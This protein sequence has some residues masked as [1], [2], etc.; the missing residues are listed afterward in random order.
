MDCREVQEKLS[1]YI[2]EEVLP[3]EKQTIEEHLLSCFSCQRE[4]KKLLAIKRLLHTMDRALEKRYPRKI[5]M[6]LQAVSKRERF[7]ELIL[8]FLLS[9]V[10]VVSLLV[11]GLWREL[12]EGTDFQRE[13]APVSTFAGFDF[14]FDKVDPRAGGNSIQVV[15][16]TLDK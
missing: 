16:F 7:R 14:R 15:E 4:M 10:A 6:E 13:I 9:G 1:L 8:V 5:A 12:Q 11:V 3:Q 2:D